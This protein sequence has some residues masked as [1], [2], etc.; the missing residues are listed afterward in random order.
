MKFPIPTLMLAA[1]LSLFPPLVALAQS[2]GT[3][4][5]PAELKAKPFIDAAAIGPLPAN[6]PLSIVRTQGGWSLVKTRDGKEGWVR[7]L[8]IAVTTDASAGGNT[9]ASVGNVLRTGTKANVATT[10]VKGLTK[11]DIKNAKPNYFEVDR[12]DNFIAKKPEVDR[13]AQSA[14]LRPQAAATLEP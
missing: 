14:Q 13:F 8:N 4:I 3:L 7:L 9:L 11:E 1:G 10:G 12:L 5:N 6:A 2:A